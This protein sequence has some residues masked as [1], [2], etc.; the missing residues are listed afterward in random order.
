MRSA[1]ICLFVCSACTGLARLDSSGDPVPDPVDAGQLVIAPPPAL[2]VDAGVD[3]GPVTG[4]DAGQPPAVVDDAEVVSVTFPSELSCG[5]SVTAQLTIRNSGTTTWTKAAGYY[6]GAVGDADPLSPSTRVSLSEGEVIAPA[7]TRTFSIPLTGRPAISSDVTDWQMLQDGVHWFGAIAARTVATACVPPGADAIDLS[8]VQ[9]FNSPADVA[10]WPI[11]T[12]LN[13]IE[14]SRNNNFGLGFT[15]PALATWPDYTIP[16]WD[17]PL[18]YTAWAIVNVGGQWFTSGYIQMWNG[19]ASTGAPL[20]TDFAN[21]WAYDG[22]WG[23]MMGHQPVVGERMGFFVTAGN[24]R[25]EGGVT[26]LRERSNVVMVAL[27]ANDEGVF[28]F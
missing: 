7:A 23:P 8:T 10:S 19:R 22:R 14:M 12:Q 27:P 15:F 17:G 4:L 28:S 3:A 18:Q 21:N 5:E 6:L 26:S 16:G 24:A 13:R 9:V 1:I 11:T 25:G 2:V 20:L